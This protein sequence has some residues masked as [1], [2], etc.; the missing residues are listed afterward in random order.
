MYFISKLSKPSVDFV[1]KVVALQA[2]QRTIFPMAVAYVVARRLSVPTEASE[3]IEAYFRLNCQVYASEVVS[4]L[5]ELVPF[6]HKYALEC[7]KRFFMFRYNALHPRAIPLAFTK[8]SAV[9]DFFGISQCFG[10]DALELLSLQSAAM[11]NYVAGL[12]TLLDEVATQTTQ[13]KDEEKDRY[14]AP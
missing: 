7:V 3:D 6:N 9:V 2:P 12:T 1:N 10:T 13:R 11:T 14:V 4:N 8:D 5:N